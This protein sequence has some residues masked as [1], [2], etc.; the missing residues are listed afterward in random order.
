MYK[1]HF[2]TAT[3]AVAQNLRLGLAFITALLFSSAVWSMPITKVLNVHVVDV[4]SSTLGCASDGPSGDKFFQNEVNAI[5]AQAGIKVTF[6]SET[7]LGGANNSYGSAG[8]TY[9]NLFY[10]IN[11]SSSNSLLNLNNL[12]GG[13]STSTVYMFLVHSVNAGGSGITFGEGWLGYGGLVI[14]M[15]TV[16]TYNRIDT[17][18]HEL[19]HNLGL[20]PNSL[21]GVNGH[22][23]NANDL[24]ASGSIR[25]VPTSISQISTNGLT[26]YDELPAAQ[27]ALIRQSS[28]LQNVV[29]EPASWLLLM[30]AMPGLIRL[31]R[32]A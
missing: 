24:M 4:C 2:H 32:R 3:T 19:G 8:V 17:V 29:D 18:A 23:T 25:H 12:F 13:A 6:V 28:L 10:N 15:D 1:N 22:S 5:Y 11:D 21:G 27:V 30:V 31:R 9:G 7:Y 14:A 16:M 26:G 20:M